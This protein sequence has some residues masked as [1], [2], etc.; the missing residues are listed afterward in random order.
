[1]REKRGEEGP[2]KEDISG[3]STL[4]RAKYF[5]TGAR[6][7]ILRSGLKTHGKDKGGKGALPEK[8]WWLKGKFRF[9]KR[10]R[11]TNILKDGKRGEQGAGGV[12][13]DGSAKAKAP[14]DNAMPNDW[15]RRF[16]K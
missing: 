12:C 3:K 15:V 6:G 13:R 10:V 9:I 7:E 11:R 4:K 2:F 5:F 8:P 14:Q 1:L 16:Q